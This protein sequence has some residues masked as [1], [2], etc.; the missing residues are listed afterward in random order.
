[1]TRSSLVAAA[2]AGCAWL[3]AASNSAPAQV[4]G[5]AKPGQFVGP[6]QGTVDAFRE[7]DDGAFENWWFLN[8]EAHLDLRRRLFGLP[9]RDGRLGYRRVNQAEAGA[10]QSALRAVADSRPKNEELR[11]LALTALAKS[12]DADL[13]PL[14]EASLRDRNHGVRRAAAL[15][16]GVLGQQAAAPLL[17]AIAAGTSSPRQE[18]DVRALAA[19]SLGLI[20]GTDALPAPRP[21]PSA[22]GGA[23]PVA[24][25]AAAAPKA[26]QLALRA[27]LARL[28]AVPVLLAWHPKA[29]MIAAALESGSVRFWTFSLGGLNDVELKTRDRKPA[30]A[31]A[32]DPSGERLAI[33]EAG[34]TVRVWRHA[35]RSDLCRLEGHSAPVAAIAWSPD[36]KRIATA[37]A[38]GTARVWLANGGAALPELE[39]GEHAA[40][41][42]AWSGDGARIAV[43]NAAGGLRVYSVQDRTPGAA[44]EPHATAVTALALSEDGATLISS[45]ARGTVGWHDVAKGVRSALA[46]ADA[47]AV[48]AVSFGAAPGLALALD[49]G[50]TLEA[51]TQGGGEPLWSL[52]GIGWPAAFGPGAR[53]LAALTEKG[54][55]AVY[56]LPAAKAQKPAPEPDAPA[57]PSARAPAAG[58]GAD[59]LMPLLASRTFDG[60]PQCVQ[61]AL[62][63]ACGLARDAALSDRA[64]RLLQDESDLS[65]EARAHF[66]LALGR[67]GDARF[68]EL[69]WQSLRDQKTPVRRAAAIGLS[70]LL[71]GRGGDQAGDAHVAR[72]IERLEL[73]GQKESDAVARLYLT[74][75]L[76]RLGGARAAAFLAAGV[77]ERAS[78]K[79][80]S[81]QPFQ[82][83]ALALTAKKSGIEALLKK[84]RLQ[85]N[86]HF[87]SALAL[88][89][90]LYG[91]E[92][93]SA[94]PDLRKELSTTRNPALAG[95]LALALGLI[96]DAEAREPIRQRLQEV[97]SDVEVIPQLA[98]GLALAGARE[99][100][101]QLL[102]ARLADP[103]QSVEARTAVLFALGLVGDASVSK[104]LL[105]VLGSDAPD[106]VRAYAA[107]ALGELID[108][109]PM[110]PL[111]RLR[112]NFDATLDLAELRIGG[113]LTML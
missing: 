112:A 13:M 42:L 99:D 26:P 97:A 23:L 70:L 102:L 105:D 86:V 56:D 96:G 57:P 84:F 38:D 89:L 11:G 94:A 111:A 47:V 40:T 17:A 64:L 33:A 77:A 71:E 67:S 12:G 95:A 83:Y 66:T 39:R 79:E 60:L 1:M 92:A 91:K 29:T 30:T 5:L 107:Q 22:S 52:R 7:T 4:P 103:R 68:L 14:I 53:S 44:L 10:I 46:A 54:G 80:L 19:V 69:V 45:D 55:I 73:Q 106:E 34:G 61:E 20:A 101:Q 25:E 16:L 82:G 90:G 87:R 81:V 78:A 28:P 41:A 74:V 100:C 85:G 37:G 75:A 88:A 76:G 49:A 109:R 8:Q 35:T 43:G 50:G 108:P 51:L 9:N 113:I 58:S 21:D 65:P 27:E 110:S 2:V 98:V 24:P 59:A 93:V 62:A 32:F 63:L 72:I 15:A 104:P 36:G 31:L 3:A 18:D 6:G 48:R